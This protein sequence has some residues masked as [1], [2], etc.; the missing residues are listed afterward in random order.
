MYGAANYTAAY[1]KKAEI[2][3]QVFLTKMWATPVFTEKRVEY[4]K[5]A[6]KW[7]AIVEGCKVAGRSSSTSSGRS[8]NSS[9]QGKPF[10]PAASTAATTTPRTQTTSFQPSTKAGGKISA[11]PGTSP[12]DPGFQTSASA[13]AAASTAAATPTWLYALGGLA[14]LGGGYYLYKNSKKSSGGV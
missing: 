13:A 5:K 12:T 14:V 11:M 8:S 3:H 9:T 1:C 4:E 7:A 2:Q 6:N 10:I